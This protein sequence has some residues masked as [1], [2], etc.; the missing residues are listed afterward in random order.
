[1]AEEQTQPERCENEWLPMTLN[2]SR[3]MSRTRERSLKDA[4]LKD[5]MY[6]GRVRM[7]IIMAD[8]ETRVDESQGESESDE[9]IKLNC[10]VG[11]ELD[12]NDILI[13]YREF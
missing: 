11:N 8:E 3:R 7:D 13:C 9:G 10:Q 5:V 1:M 2:V 12:S 4:R 6:K